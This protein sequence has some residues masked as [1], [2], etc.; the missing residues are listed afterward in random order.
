MYTSLLARGIKPRTGLEKQ[1]ARQSMTTYIVFWVVTLLIL[2]VAIY[3]R[4]RTLP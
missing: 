2:I 1:K 3:L 4:H